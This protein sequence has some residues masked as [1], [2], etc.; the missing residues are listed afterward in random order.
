MLVLIAD[1]DYLSVY[2]VDDL[3][4]PKNSLTFTGPINP[5]QIDRSFDVK[6]NLLKIWWSGSREK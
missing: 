5:A 2:Y 1:L 4:L 6:E 3:W